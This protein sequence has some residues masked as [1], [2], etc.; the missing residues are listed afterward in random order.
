M[1]KAYVFLATGFEE[2][3]A[4]GT[5]DVL[6]R[7][8]MHVVTVSMTGAATVKGG[9][10]IPVVADALFEDLSYA[11]A[12]VLV[13]PGGGP[14]LN[15]Y[16]AL[17]KEIVPASRWQLFALRRSFSADWDCLKASARH[18]IR[19]LKST[20]KV[21]L[22]LMYRRLPMVLSLPVGDRDWFSISG[23]LYWSISK[24]SSRRNKSPKIY[25]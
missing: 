13:L 8:G 18:V 16:E 11:D 24:G 7:G 5:I 12:D 21:Q 4:I 25:Y 3:E 1:K 6:R 19:D 23:W 2:V 15:D 20:S 9:H 17:K 22:L 10:D 14:M